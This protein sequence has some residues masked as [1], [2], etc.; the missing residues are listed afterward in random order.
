MSYTKNKAECKLSSSVHHEISGP[1]NLTAEAECKLSGSVHQEI[2]GLAGP[3]PKFFDWSNRRPLTG[4]VWS[5][6]SGWLN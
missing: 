5:S 1:A 2:A 3:L 4:P 6:P